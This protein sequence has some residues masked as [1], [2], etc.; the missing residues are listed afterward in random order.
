MVQMV[1]VY[2]YY[3]SIVWL[4]QW[5]MSI[6]RALKIAAYWIVFEFYKRLRIFWNYKY[7]WAGL[8]G[9]AGHHIC[10]V[11]LYIV[12]ITEDRI[13]F[14]MQ[15]AVIKEGTNWERMRNKYHRKIV[16]SIL[17]SLIAEKKNQI[18]YMWLST[19]FINDWCLVINTSN[20][21]ATFSWEF[22]WLSMYKRHLNFTL[23]IYPNTPSV[24]NIKIGKKKEFT[25]RAA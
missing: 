18:L 25:D 14:P 16:Y 8:V 10:V 7:N 2:H 5:M 4:R 11:E 6:S 3:C 13:T 21:K 24:G 23:Y 12:F 20:S 15:Q 22:I 17:H 9:D 1:E 19:D